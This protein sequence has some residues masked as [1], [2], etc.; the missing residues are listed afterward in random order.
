MRAPT[1][2]CMTREFPA[3]QVPGIARPRPSSITRE[4]PCITST[5]SAPHPS[6]YYKGLSLPLPLA[7][8]CDLIIACSACCVRRYYHSI[9]QPRAVFFLCPA[10]R[11]R[12]RRKRRRPG[13]LRE[14]GGQAK[15]AHEGAL[16]NG[17]LRRDEQGRGEL[18]EGVESGR[19]GL[20]SGD[21]RG[22]AEKPLSLATLG[23]PWARGGGR[24]G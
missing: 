13:E 19:K 5:R 17:G 8:A 3:L 10:R 20:V 6:L 1:P 12:R 21:G 4:F 24:L 15:A 9:L 16:P 23:E 14:R 18:G 7:A 2:L 22:V 11:R